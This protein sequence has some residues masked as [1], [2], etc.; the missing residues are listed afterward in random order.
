MSDTDATD[1]YT[2]NKLKLIPPGHKY[3]VRLGNHSTGAEAEGLSYTLTVDANNSLFIYKFAVVLE[4]PSHSEPEQPRF[5]IRVKDQN[6]QIIDECTEYTVVAAASIPNF[7]SVGEIRWRD[8]T[9]VG[10]DLSPYIGQTVTIELMTGDCSQ[11]GHFGYAYFVAQCAPMELT[12]NY[13]PGSNTA[14]IYAPEGFASYL[15]DSGATTRSETVIAP[16]EDQVFSCE[17][18]SV[19]GCKA[20]LSAVMSIVI[21]HAD[22][23]NDSCTNTITFSN[24]STVNI[25]ELDYLWDFGDGTA[26]TEENP[27]HVY[28]TAGKYDVTL[29]ATSKTVGC[30]DVITKNINVIL[31]INVQ[32][33]LAC[34]KSTP[35]LTAS[36]TADN[37]VFSWYED[38]E[39]SNLILQNNSMQTDELIADTEF[40][41]EVSKNNCKLRDTLKITVLPLPDLHVKDTAIC[42]NET[43][44]LTA[45]SSDAV[46]INWYNDS[47]Y[48]DI[49]VPSISFTTE[50]LESSTVF[51]VEATSADGCIMRDSSHVVV[52]PLPDLTVKDTTVCS[53]IMTMF[54]VSS[55]NA[56]SIMWYSDAIYSNI[57]AQTSSHETML[58]VDTAFYIEALSNE[59]CSK[60][61]TMDISVIKHPMV[62][63]MNDMY[64]CYGEE[65]TLS[66]LE[67]DGTLSWDV[68]PTTVRPLH[69][70]DYIVKASRQ[71]CP[72]VYDTVTI[73]V[74][75]SLYIYPPDLP[76]YRASA[77]YNQQINSNAQSPIYTLVGGNL[78]FG[79]SLYSSGNL[80]GNPYSDELTSVFT[81]QVEDNHKCTTTYEY[82]LEKEFYM[83]KVFTPNGDG[84]NDIFM[85]G[86]KI[87]IFD[88]LGLEIFRGDDGWDGTYKNK[89]APPDIYFYLITREIENGKTKIHTGYIGIR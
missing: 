78:P 6:D 55:Q 81:V 70:Q 89:P 22:F 15:W 35:I 26:S 66:V 46:S 67:S 47:D 84:I 54:S 37:V 2:E 1:P 51:Y 38:S 11:G 9:T 34:A 71:F 52:N 48:S 45:S 8:W 85:K 17:L 63:A 14:T 27:V 19:T 44:T 57:I 41:V 5:Q 80:S 56:A 33:I 24:L 21:T 4:D 42:Y 40:Y 79:L 88:R 86:Y 83:P 25:G 49:I 10:L 60:K 31:D 68:N 74:G 58:T 69:S 65:A 7:Q 76:S 50:N 43:A 77:D 30:V 32:D 64:L 18:T 82:S 36:S 59:G 62:V 29:T 73:T 87:I 61:D 75:D 13:C 23:K 3:S 16:E 20:K 28:S 39:Y 12:A 72:D 53:E